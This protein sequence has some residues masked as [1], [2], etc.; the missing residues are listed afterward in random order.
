VISFVCGKS[1]VLDGTQ[2]NNT[3]PLK[4]NKRKRGFYCVIN[5]KFT[6]STHFSVHVMANDGTKSIFARKA[7]QK[8]RLLF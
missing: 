8:Q 6:K 7:A 2:H 5:D 3:S 1:T 4:L